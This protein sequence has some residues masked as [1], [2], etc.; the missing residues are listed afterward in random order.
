MSSVR[1]R[2]RRYYLPGSWVSGMKEKRVR[3]VSRFFSNALVQAWMRAAASRFT[4][5][6]VCWRRARAPLVQVC[7]VRHAARDRRRAAHA[8]PVRASTLIMRT[9][10]VRRARWS[11]RSRLARMPLVQVWM[12]TAEARITWRSVSWCRARAPLVQDCAFQHAASGRRRAARPIPSRA[13]A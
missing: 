1:A 9:A 8:R 4:R 3:R 13:S 5:P 6:S 11:I 2:N 10:A 12:R 7:A